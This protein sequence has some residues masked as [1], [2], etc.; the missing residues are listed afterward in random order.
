MLQMPRTTSQGA[1]QKSFLLELASRRELEWR[2]AY[3]L[4]TPCP[5]VCLRCCSAR[6]CA[7][8][9]PCLLTARC[10]RPDP[11]HACWA[12][13]HARAFVQLLGCVGAH[14]G[15][16]GRAAGRIA[17]PRAWHSLLPLPCA[18]GA[19]RQRSRA[20]CRPAPKHICYNKR[21]PC[22]PHPPTSELRLEP[23]GHL[24][25]HF[26]LKYSSNPA[27]PGSPICRGLEAGHC[28]TSAVRSH[29]HPA[30]HAGA[31]IIQTRAASEQE[32][33]VEATT[34]G[35]TWQHSEIPGST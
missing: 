1:I 2:H 33:R 28:M 32:H 10:R 20:R 13:G 22:S 23:E 7:E 25:T 21:A 3:L 16:S 18:P 24:A 17:R 29:L 12:L 9:A 27:Q 26:L 35:S 11:R 8:P 31:S 5:R 4:I 19:V 6:T 34:C 30:V 14:C 15:D